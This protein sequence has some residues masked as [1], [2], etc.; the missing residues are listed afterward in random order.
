MRIYEVKCG[1]PLPEGKYTPSRGEYAGVSL[2]YRHYAAGDKGGLLKTL[3][4]EFKYVGE[5]MYAAD[6]RMNEMADSIL[7]LGGL[8]LY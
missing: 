3:E 1:A 4:I 6:S 2:S 7:Y 8:G 5:A